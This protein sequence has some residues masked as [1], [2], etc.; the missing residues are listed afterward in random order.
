VLDWLKTGLHDQHVLF[1]QS[2]PA[3]LLQQFESVSRNIICKNVPSGGF[4][5][6]TRSII[7]EV[8]ATT[9]QLQPE[10]V[11]SWNQGYANF[12][13]LGSRL[14]GCKKSI[15]H[16]GCAPEKHSLG[17][18]YDYYV[19]WP[20]ALCGGKAVCA[21]NHIYSIINRLRFFPRKIFHT[22]P[23]C[24]DFMRFVKSQKTY[25]GN[26]EAALVANLEPAKDHKILLD[27]WR[28][29]VDKIPGARL[30]IIGGGSL[31]S[32]I[33]TQVKD[34]RLTENVKM[35]GPRSDVPELLWT[36]S[37]FVF[38]STRNEGF[39]TVLIEAL[40]A[41]M[42]VVSFAEPAPKEVLQDGKYGILAKE[43]TPESLAHAILVAFS[44]PLDSQTIEKHIS[45]AEQFSPDR[46][47]ERYITIVNET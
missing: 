14:G 36:Y 9:K 45:Y 29:V 46:M 5:Q 23:N 17:F 38:S 24:I 39:G 15:V 44:K 35:L 7:R 28:L 40:A 25:S 19:F 21:S 2:N 31:Y 6:R 20:V 33:E 8:Q 11:I 41:C 34:L 27:A 30:H 42:Q 3:D 1:L 18:W 26:Q 10:L 13:V 4:L 47:V 12:I 37:L 43:R 22:I 32:A 16:V